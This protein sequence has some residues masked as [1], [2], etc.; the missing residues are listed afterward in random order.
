VN[1]FVESP[2]LALF[3]GLLYLLCS[4]LVF[5]RTR[6]SSFF[7]LLAYSEYF[8]IVGIGFGAIFFGLG[9]DLDNKIYE[10]YI[11]QNGLIS[12]YT[13]YH[14]IFFSI[15]MFSGTFIDKIVGMQISIGKVAEDSIKSNNNQVFWYRGLIFLGLIFLF[16]YMSLVGPVTA[17]VTAATAR[18]GSDEG[19]E[20]ASG[21]LFLKNIA[22]IGI[23]SIIFFPVIID[24]KR[25]KFDVFL[26]CFYGILLYVLT[27][28]R[29][30]ILDTIIISVLIWFSRARIGV[31]KKA[32]WFFALISLGL[33]FTLYGKG[34][35]DSLFAAGF[36]G[37]DVVSEEIENF[38]GKIIGQFIHLIYSIDAG[39]KYF[40]ENGPTISKALLLSPLGVFPG[41]LYSYLNLEALSWQ[42]V[43]LSDNIVCLNTFSYP[44][45]EPCTMPPYYSG[46]SA[47]F[48]PIIFG[49]LFG[50]AKFYI[51]QRISRLWYQLRLQPAKLWL[52]LLYFIVFSKL[53]LLIPNVIGLFSF[54]TLFAIGLYACRNLLNKLSI[55]NVK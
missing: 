33:L 1:S 35:S 52:P 29:A 7:Y 44:D 32:L 53:S 23:I 21:Y 46:V 8:Y 26:I 49:F 20:G 13:F 50:F 22:Q 14:I 38:Y 51:Y 4:L 16:I 17:L 39:V 54:F 25:F 11:L 45:A 40:F 30:A 3:S 27:G 2:L 15:G 5:A 41:W 47:Y 34:L 43:D 12:D 31:A 24:K 28:A 36:G 9:L 6:K 37:G 10:T 19:L 48:G 55:S 18:A 42:Q